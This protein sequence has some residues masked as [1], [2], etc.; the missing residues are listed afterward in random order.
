MPI[1]AH[2]HQVDRDPDIGAG[3]IAFHF[4]P[5]TVTG[6]RSL[7]QWLARRPGSAVLPLPGPPRCGAAC[8][9]AS[10][11]FGGGENRCCGRSKGCC[12]VA[13]RRSVPD[14]GAVGPLIR[15]KALA[16]IAVQA[17]ACSGCTSGAPSAPNHKPLPIIEGDA[18][19]SFAR[20]PGHHRR[21]HYRRP[22]HQPYARRVSTTRSEHHL[23]PTMPPTQLGRAPKAS[24]GYCRH[25]EQLGLRPRDNCLS[26]KDSLSCSVPHRS[27]A[28][29]R[30]VAAA[31]QRS[32]LGGCHR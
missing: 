20:L 2:P 10:R 16:F 15:S 4:R 32:C 25:R 30:G 22:V 27:F 12:L 9:P 28:T 24:S 17:R 26:K 8:C 6:R 13:T 31:H 19:M 11:R 14:S 1:D 29:L 21:N 7:T 23:F 3:V 5:R 18:E